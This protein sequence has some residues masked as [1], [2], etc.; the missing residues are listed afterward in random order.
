MKKLMKFT[1]NEIRQKFL[2]F[3][4][5]KGHFITQSAPLI[6]ENDASVLFNVAGMQPMVPYLL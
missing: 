3:M 1:T 5:T 6:P 4:E 2:E